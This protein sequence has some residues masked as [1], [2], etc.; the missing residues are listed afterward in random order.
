MNEPLPPLPE[1]PDPPADAPW[2]RVAPLDGRAA[3]DRDVRL[4]DVIFGV[5]GACERCLPKRVAARYV[6]WETIDDPAFLATI[7][8]KD[9]EAPAPYSSRELL[10]GP[11]V[12]R[13]R[14]DDDPAEG[15]HIARIHD[16]TEHDL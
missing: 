16:I 3:E 14:L 4:L 10:C 13:A 11:C 5:Q 6:L 2:P 15:L 8:L 9:E 1:R 12:S 7:A